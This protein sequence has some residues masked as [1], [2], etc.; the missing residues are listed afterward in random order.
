MLAKLRGLKAP[1]A[2]NAKPSKLVFSRKQLA[3]PGQLLGDAEEYQTYLEETARRNAPPPPP[4]PTTYLVELP[5]F[6]Q[7]AAQL[8][9]EASSDVLDAYQRIVYEREMVRQ[10]MEEAA[11]TASAL[12]ERKHLPHTVSALLGQAGGIPTVG[13]QLKASAD[14]RTLARY[15]G[16]VD[17]WHDVAAH[18]AVTLDKEVDATLLQRVYE[19]NRKW[20]MVQRLERAEPLVFTEAKYTMM[21]RGANEYY[22]WLGNPLSGLW[23]A[24]RPNCFKLAAYEVVA[25]PAA[26]RDDRPAALGRPLTPASTRSFEERGRAWAKREPLVAHVAAM[27]KYIAAVLPYEPEIDGLYVRGETVRAQILEQTDVT[28]SELEAKLA[29]VNPGARGGGQHQPVGGGGLQAGAARA[30]RPPRYF[31]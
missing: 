17:E 9:P 20:Q 13:E 10:Q 15:G 7:E 28:L 30:S 23:T 14:G 12:E 21:L 3:K 4:E 29:Q 31:S 2:E 26:M 24:I 1:E 18:T 8:A 6:V 16:I 22:T 11:Q 27:G 19:H 25:K 5:A